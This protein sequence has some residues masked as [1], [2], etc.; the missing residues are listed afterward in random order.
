MSQARGPWGPDPV[1]TF[2][3]LFWWRMNAPQEAA[4]AVNEGLAALGERGL[5]PV[6]P[7]C[8][9]RSPKDVRANL[10]TAMLM[11]LRRDEAGRPMEW[12]LDALEAIDFAAAGVSA[13][14]GGERAH[15]R[16]TRTPAQK[17]ADIA[18]HLQAGMA[19]ED[20]FK[21]AGVSRATGYRLVA[22]RQRDS[23]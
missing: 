22:R 5:P 11:T 4:Q 3:T 8:G 13:F 23:G 10:C 17:T 20:A 12:W 7:V 1:D 18:R 9:R 19:V 6:P 16:K 2:H 15:F 21:A 14:F